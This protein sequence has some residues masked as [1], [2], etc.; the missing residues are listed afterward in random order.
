MNSNWA[1]QNIVKVARWHHHYW[2]VEAQQTYLQSLQKA[3]DQQLADSQYPLKDDRTT[4]VARF[5]NASGTFVIKRY[6]PRNLWHTISRSL[7]V[8]RARRCWSMSY[9]FQQAG[10]NVA[11]PVMMY[12]WRFGPLRGNAYFINRF[13][14]GEELLTTLPSMSP[15]LQNDVLLAVRHAFEV[16]RQNHLSHGDMKASNLLWMDGELFFIDLDAARQHLNSVTWKAANR[17][18]KKRFLKNWQDQPEL[19]ALFSEI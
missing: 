5:N 14:R 6:N 11:E 16:M 18:D 15:T 1:K 17:K 13:L 12:E 4:T 9:R 7:R 8:S 19:L 2:F 3:L 10:L